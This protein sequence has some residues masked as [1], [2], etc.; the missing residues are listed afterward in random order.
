M[1]VYIYIYVRVHICSYIYNSISIYIYMYIISRY[2]HTGIDMFLMKLKKCVVLS[3]LGKI[4]TNVGDA[5]F[6]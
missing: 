4:F 2:I 6:Y 1:N 3:V 5:H